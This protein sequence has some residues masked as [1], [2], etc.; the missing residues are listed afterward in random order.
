MPKLAE[1][2]MI[3]ANRPVLAQELD[4]VRN[5]PVIIPFANL[6]EILVGKPD[7]GHKRRD[8]Y[9]LTAEIRNILD[10]AVG[11]D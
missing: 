2:L 3:Q 9:L 6:I 7:E 8:D 1:K 4:D 10:D 5:Q 11:V